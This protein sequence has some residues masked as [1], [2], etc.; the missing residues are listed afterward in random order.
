[1]EKLSKTREGR[2]H[3]THA[4]PSRYHFFLNKFST[5]T[6]HH[7]TPAAFTAPSVAKKSAEIVK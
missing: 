7:L 4:R 2:N 6:E 5:L 3:P 1:M